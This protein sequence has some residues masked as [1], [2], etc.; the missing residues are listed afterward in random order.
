MV[1][2]LI[3]PSPV[4]SALSAARGPPRTLLQLL[5]RAW[6]S[7]S[8]SASSAAAAASAALARACA[9][10]QV[11][12]LLLASAAG[13]P[14]AWPFSARLFACSLALALR[15]ASLLGRGRGSIGG[16]GGGGGGAG[17]AGGAVWAMG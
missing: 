5:L 7:A 1:S 14:G 10:A 9:S 6:A 4:P 17:S 11:A 2:G 8:S 15:A 12:L 3:P 16:A 13:R